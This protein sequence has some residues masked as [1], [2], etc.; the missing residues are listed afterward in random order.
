MVPPGYVEETSWSP[1]GLI[2]LGN[3]ENRENSKGVQ[4]NISIKIRRIPLL[5]KKNASEIMAVFAS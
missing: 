4:R 5:E 2:C 1:T 3:Q